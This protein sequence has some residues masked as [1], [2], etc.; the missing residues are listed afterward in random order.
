MADP[1]HTPP[2]AKFHR[3][4][5]LDARP[6]L[7]FAALVLCVLAGIGLLY[8]SAVYFLADTELLRDRPVEEVRTV[9]LIVH[10]AYFVVGG[11]ILFVT[12]LL[13]THRFVGPAYVMQRAVAGMRRGDYSARL[14]LRKRDSHRAA[15]AELRLL[16]DELAEREDARREMLQR[17]ERFLEAG[18]MTGARNCVQELL[19]RSVGDRA[20]AA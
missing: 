7:T 16:R 5:L 13:L 10:T 8:A 3:R 15:V 19:E 6:Q 2:R 4:Y 17:L 12:V 20:Q 9:L 1:A 11:A 14:G 18:E